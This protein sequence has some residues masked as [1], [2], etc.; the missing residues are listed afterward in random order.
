MLSEQIGLERHHQRSPRSKHLVEKGPCPRLFKLKLLCALPVLLENTTP[1]LERPPF[2]AQ[3]D[4]GDQR[5]RLDVGCFVRMKADVVAAVLVL[6]D[7]VVIGRRVLV[8]SDQRV[9]MCTGPHVIVVCNLQSLRRLRYVGS[10]R[11]NSMLPSG[12]SVHEDPV[13]FRIASLKPHLPS[14]EIVAPIIQRLV[15]AIDPLRPERLDI[16]AL[17]ACL[18]LLSHVRKVV[19]WIDAEHLLRKV[20]N[21]PDAIDFGV[22]AIGVAEKLFC[23]PVRHGLSLVDDSGKPV[24]KPLVTDKFIRPKPSAHEHLIGKSEVPV[25]CNSVLLVLLLL[26]PICTVKDYLHSRNEMEDDF[27]A[28]GSPTKVLCPRNVEEELQAQQ[29]LR[30]QLG[31]DQPEH[32]GHVSATGEAEMKREIRE[33]RKL[34]Q[35]EQ[36]HS[37]A[38]EEENRHLRKDLAETKEDRDYAM[39]TVERL[40]NEIQ[41]LS[42]EMQKLRAELGDSNQREKQLQEKYDLLSDY[43]SVRVESLHLYNELIPKSYN[44]SRQKL[45]DGEQIS[46]TDPDIGMGRSYRGHLYLYHK[47][48]RSMNRLDVSE[49]SLKKLRGHTPQLR[50][51]EY[52]LV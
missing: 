32:G 35:K 24:W 17:A 42:A 9:L 29:E 45:Q 36:D 31:I 11:H 41:K 21:L 46:T 27:G 28:T 4:N 39:Q 47:R 10:R 44:H 37:R 22:D 49:N 2:L 33:A 26:V 34:A 43:S 20:I 23:R 6:G 3:L 14:L 25:N 12:V 13:L 1:D 5:P 52:P 40:E 38:A 18:K 8:R 16:I 30:E 50:G 15:V 7:N 51:Y 48:L 19:G